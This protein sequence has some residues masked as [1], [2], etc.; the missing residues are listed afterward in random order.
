MGQEDHIHLGG[1]GEEELPMKLIDDLKI[2]TTRQN[3]R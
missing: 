3:P 2:P 1:E